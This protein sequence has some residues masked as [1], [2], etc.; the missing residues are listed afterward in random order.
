LTVLFPRKRITSLPTE[1]QM[2]KRAVDLS[3]EELAAMGAKAARLAVKRARRAGLTITGT[4]D[5]YKE[6]QAA[7]VLAQLHPSGTVTLVEERDFRSA[8]GK[9]LP[10]RRS[11]D[12]A[13][14]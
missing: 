5:T 9:A 13:V 11:Q 12:R 14:D 3:V 7:S 4:V 1:L 10:A 2:A 8:K 6:G